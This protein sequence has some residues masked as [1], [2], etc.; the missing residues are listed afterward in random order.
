VRIKARSISRSVAERLDQRLPAARVW[1]VFERSFHL[2]ASDSQVTAVVLPEIGDGPIS[3]VVDAH[4][5][6]LA[7]LEPGMPAALD[8]GRLRVGELEVSVETAVVWEPCPEWQRL[9]GRSGSGAGRLL[10]IQTLCER[11][12]PTG[13][14]MMLT[15]PGPACD[16]HLAQTDAPLGASLVFKEAQEAATTLR[17]GWEGDVALL[18]SG[19]AQLAG[20]GGGLTPAGDD[21]LCGFMLWAWL[22]H[23]SPHTV[24][25][26][27]L[28]TAAPRTTIL[29]AAFLQAATRGECSP[30]WQSLLAALS[31]GTDEELAVAVQEVL[32]YGATSGADALAGFLW[33]GL[34]G[35]PSGGTL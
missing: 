24:C 21:F 2:V 11:L 28:E 18:Q 9:R 33:A 1:A 7:T 19:A 23:P 8:D 32:A 27:L 14:L 15:D 13:T 34:C 29:S 12:A 25:G 16:P 31:G 3:I 4:P 20:L 26:L 5:S 17:Q 22:A 10:L 6:D 30:A 35:T